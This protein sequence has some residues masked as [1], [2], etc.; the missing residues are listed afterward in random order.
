MNDETDN[1]D[2]EEDNPTPDYSTKARSTLTSVDV[3]DMMELQTKW[4]DRRL[5]SVENFVKDTLSKF[6]SKESEK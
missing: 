2:I 1:R 3:G 6:F 5:A 4:L